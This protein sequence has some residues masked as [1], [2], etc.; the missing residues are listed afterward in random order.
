MLVL[1]SQVGRKRKIDN[2]G[3]NILELY[4]VLVKTYELPYKLPNHLRLS[5]L[6]NGNILEKYQIWV[7]TA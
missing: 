1:R 2:P 4:N 6:R 7:E 3:H 5:F